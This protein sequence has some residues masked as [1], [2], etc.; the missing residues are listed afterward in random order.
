MAALHAVLALAAVA[1]VGHVAFR[2][3]GRRA[4][5]SDR[6]SSRFRRAFAV[7][8]PVVAVAAAIALLIAGT[9]TTVGDAL[10]AVSP[11]LASSPVGGFAVRLAFLLGVAGVVL[12]CY[13]GSVPHLRAARG[14]TLTDRQAA[15]R[16]GRLLV[17]MAL[18]VALTIQAFLGLLT[19][20]SATATFVA[21]VAVLAV[22]ALAG[23]PWLIER[24]RDA[25]DPT[26]EEAAV[27]DRADLDV[28][29][30]RVVPGVDDRSATAFVRGPP[31]RHRL[32]V[33]DYLFEALDADSAAAVAA[34]AAARERAR[35][36]PYRVVVAAVVLGVLGVEP[37][38]DALGA[39][40]AAVGLPGWTAAVGYLLGAAALLAAGKRLV[41]RGDDLAAAT[42]GPGRLADALERVAEVNDLSLDAGRLSALARMRPSLGSRIDRLRRRAAAD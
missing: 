11:A 32:F 20:A 5:R 38:R 1:A 25:R 33:T 34:A 40:V 24:L 23:S 7:G 28:A 13:L 30:V 14:A 9:P 10:A 15:R 18:A 35:Y 17:G 22:L 6:P 2:L 27:L 4:R 26:P 29:A 39:A 37:A 42:V 19:V 21:V 3:H 36:T 8:L 41:Y 31:G 12:V 16:F